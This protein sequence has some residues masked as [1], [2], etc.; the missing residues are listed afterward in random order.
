MN[1][2]TPKE[3]TLFVLTLI[4]SIFPIVPLTILSSLMI[5][6]FLSDIGN[7]NSMVYS[8]IPLWIG[9]FLLFLGGPVGFIGLIR[10]LLNKRTFSSLWLIIY[11]ALSYSIVVGITLVSG[12]RDIDLM[13]V[14]F[15]GYLLLS[16]YI[17]AVQ[18]VKTY[19]ASTAISNSLP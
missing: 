10:I 1:F 4:F 9:G 14:I 15:A 19:Q 12:S 13:Q 16:L 11:G 2:K 17:I 5:V 7:G 3:K 8:R 18:I 6:V